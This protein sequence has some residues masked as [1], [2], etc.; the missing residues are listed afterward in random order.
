MRSLIPQSLVRRWNGEGG[1]RDVCIVAIPLILSTSSWSIQHFVDRMFLTW[2][3]TESIA[4]AIPA[5]FLSFTTMSLFI[6]TA[7]YVS[8]FVAQY[9]GA[10]RLDR[11]PP[12]IWQGVYIALI[13]GIVHLLLIPLAPAFFRFVGHDAL[14]QQ[15]EVVYFQVLCMGAFPS[16]ASN[17]FSG[18]FT[19]LGKTWPVMWVNIIATGVNI[20]FDYLLIFGN[21]GFPE[22]GIGGAALATV[23]AG[24]VYCVAYMV[25]LLFPQYR[26]VYHP[27]S[28]WAFN[29]KIFSRLIRFGFPNGVQYFIDV[30]G[31]TVFLLLVGRLG[32]TN[33]AATNIAFNV[34]TLAFMPMI[35]FGIAVSV[36]VGQYIGKKSP[37]VAERSVYSGFHLTFIYMFAVSCC[38]VLIP[39]LFLEPFAAKVD[40]AEF[41]PIRLLT[42]VLLR[43]VALYSIFDTLNIIFA[44]ALKG[45]GDTRFVMYMLTSVST[46]VLIIPSYVVIVVFNQGIYVAWGIATAYVIILG[47]AF[48]VRYRG[49]KWKTMSVIERGVLCLTPTVPEIPT[50]E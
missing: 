8:I 26:R 46:L 28:G 38:Y 41:E 48:L 33:L 36:M 13:G 44:S 47:V 12:S 42:I 16:L 9:Y 39:D 15:Q 40:P 27:Y 3:S 31:F 43:F 5:G 1:Y 7:S 35:G 17:A 4:A 49:G 50:G 24:V 2:Y 37:D 14:V 45:A 21:F 20:I 29:F 22:M 32:I 6:G 19:G 10:G 11:I 34:N 30:A 23:L 18:Y 25:I